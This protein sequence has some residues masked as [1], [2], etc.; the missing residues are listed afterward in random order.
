MKTVEKILL[1][2]GLLAF[3]ILGWK[4]PWPS[5]THAVGAVGFGFV[6]IFSQEIVA[7][8][9]NTLGW[10]V[11]FLPEHRA[12]VPSFWRLLR[13][14]IAGDGVHYM[15]PSAIV[16]G[17]MAKANMIGDRHPIASRLSS[18]VVA[19]F[20]QLLAFAIISVGSL[21]LVVRGSVDFAP[22]RAQLGAGMALLGGLIAVLII[23]EVRA[24]FPGG[25]KE[26]PAKAKGWSVVAMIDQDVRTFLRLHPGRFALSTLFYGLAYI[27]S[28]FEA[29]WIARFLGLPI[30][31]KTALIIEILSTSADGM[32]FMVPAKAGTQEVTKT[33]IFTALG[34]P[35]A[36]GFAFGLVRHAR[37]ILWSL[38]GWILYYQD[39]RRSAK[40]SAASQAASQGAPA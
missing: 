40:D 27:W 17:E 34:L 6:L 30:S 11:A 3:V 23:L 12:Q 9:F 15:I 19:K 29:Y 5:I 24:C 39:R 13:L 28:A 22:F 20:T 7:H 18:I 26:K 33:A 38:V 36:S 14:R 2:V 4:M 35:K 32:F 21:W 1:A 10:W 37:E 25:E 16:A 8:L 31:I